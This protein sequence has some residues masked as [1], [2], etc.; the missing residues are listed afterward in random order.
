MALRAAAAAALALAVALALGALHA[1]PE[2]A[3]FRA[4][5]VLPFLGWPVPSG[6][7]EPIG[8]GLYKLDLPW[9]VTP[10]HRETL[11]VYAL[12]LGG[13]WAISDAGGFD[14]PWQRYASALHD[15]LRRLMG[16][17][18]TLALVLR[19]CPAVRCVSSRHRAPAHAR[20]L[21][22]SVAWPLE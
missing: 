2:L 15:A 11:D 8:S 17:D 5:G 4:P 20:A 7:F 21:L 12:D 19:A 13:K 9:Y 18:G 6:G 10:F 16:P 3:M 1:T 22:R 14:T